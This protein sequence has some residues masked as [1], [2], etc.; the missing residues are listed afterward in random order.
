MAA[1]ANNSCDSLF[2]REEPSQPSAEACGGDRANLEAGGL[3]NGPAEPARAIFGGGAA[4]GD[5]RENHKFAHAAPGSSRSP[6]G[7]AAPMGS[8]APTDGSSSAQPKCHE[9]AWCLSK[10]PRASFSGSQMA[11][12]ARRRCKACVNLAPSL[13]PPP[14]PQPLPQQQQQPTPPQT[15]LPSPP[16]PAAVYKCLYTRPQW[17][18]SASSAAER[19]ARRLY[20]QSVSGDDWSRLQH[21]ADVLRRIARRVG[22]SPAAPVATVCTTNQEMNATSTIEWRRMV[23]DGGD[24]AAVMRRW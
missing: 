12:G 10:L 4:R 13:P 21:E 23:C 17:K 2:T 7:A 24:V 16:A 1:A 9:C 8:E 14:P 18:A 19:T 15:S 20:I 22:V 6:A 3:P 11:K 5:P